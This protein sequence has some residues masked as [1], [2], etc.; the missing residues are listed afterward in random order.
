[1]SGKPFNKPSETT[2]A[3]AGKP[4]TGPTNKPVSPPPASKP[5]PATNKPKTGK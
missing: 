2:K 3:P 5:A 4:G 1:M